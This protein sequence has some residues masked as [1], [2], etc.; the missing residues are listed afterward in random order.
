MKKKLQILVVGCW[1][2]IFGSIKGQNLVPNYSFETI[3]STCYPGQIIGATP[4]QEVNSPNLFSNSNCYPSNSMGVPK[5]FPGFQYSKTGNNYAGFLLFQ[6]TSEG[7][8]FREWAE[9][10]LTD[11]LLPGKNYCVSFY[12]SLADT[13]Q[14]A[15]ANIQAL[16]S[17]TLI[18]HLIDYTPPLYDSTF[19]HYYPANINNPT[20]SIIT[21]TMNWTKIE[22]TYSPN[23][24]KA[25]MLV[26]NFDLY[27]QINW[28]TLP[29]NTNWL[30]AYYYLDMVSV[31]EIKPA[32]TRN[33]TTVN[34]CDSL[35]L[36]N[37]YDDNAAYTWWPKTNMNDSTLANP[38]AIPYV[39]TMYYVKKVQCSSVTYD[40]IKVT[41]QNCM[42]SVN[43]INLKNKLKV[44]P[45]PNS[46]NFTVN[47]TIEQD[48]KLELYDIQGKKVYSI[49]LLATEN[50]IEVTTTDLLNG[51]YMYKLVNQG[52]ILQNGR[53]VIIK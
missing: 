43:E 17:D 19:L 48:A 52:N 49:N 51:V 45:N 30:G 3:S 22:G 14:Y 23:T 42:I 13:S 15:I 8:D 5:N 38:T 9:I 29:Y 50:S 21:D 31:T 46:G 34:N 4:W 26:G 40:S 16:F 41:V 20:G 47:Y 11:T 28:I 24:K 18:T 27:N 35:V 33:D 2:L 25:Y 44:Q 32:L 53:L 7:Q 6:N 39:T 36:G 1:F 12:T 37:N 10:K